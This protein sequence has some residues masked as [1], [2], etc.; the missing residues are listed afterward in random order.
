MAVQE[1]DAYLLPIVSEKVEK[2]FQM[3]AVDARTAK[4]IAEEDQFTTG[5]C[6]P[7][8]HGLTGGWV[9]KFKASYLA[10]FYS[11]H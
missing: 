7:V 1:N 4:P 11:V 6:E 9:Q 8:H 5:Q 2:E 10:F 3:R